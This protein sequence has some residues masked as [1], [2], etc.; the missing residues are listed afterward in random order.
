VSPNPINTHEL[1]EQGIGPTAA[2]LIPAVK[3]TYRRAQGLTL[4]ERLHEFL[5]N[6]FGGYTS[7]ATNLRGYWV[8]PT[9]ERLYGE[10]REYRVF[11]NGGNSTLALKQFLAEIASEIDEQCIC[12]AS[13]DS[14]CLIFPLAS[15]AAPC[16]T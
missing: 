16:E 12:F 2:F 1:R 6:Q 15:R 4:E 13:G 11:T 7:P 14:S 10:H 9:G 8:S 5:L 3:L